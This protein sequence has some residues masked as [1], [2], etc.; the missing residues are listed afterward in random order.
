M[1]NTSRIKRKIPSLL[2]DSDSTTKKGWRDL[3]RNRYHYAQFKRQ[4]PERCNTLIDKIVTDLK[5]LEKAVS[6][7][8]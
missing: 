8:L 3:M 2:L 6:E 4:N 1:V 7:N 5:E